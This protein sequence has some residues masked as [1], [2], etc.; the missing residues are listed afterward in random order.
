MIKKV[1]SFCGFFWIYH[2]K[3][4]ACS[5][6][7]KVTGKQRVCVHKSPKV[8]YVNFYLGVPNTVPFISIIK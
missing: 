3:P 6:Y 7:L 2:G 4:V 1:T 5:V 8:R